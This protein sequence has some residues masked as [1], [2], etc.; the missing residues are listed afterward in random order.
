MVSYTPENMW[1]E[2]DDL[3]CAPGFKEVQCAYYGGIRVYPE[4]KIVTPKWV[5]SKRQP[6]F[7][8]NPLSGE[9]LTP[10]TE[11]NLTQFEREYSNGVR[12]IYPWMLEPLQT[13]TTIK[14]TNKHIIGI[15]AEEK[16]KKEF[17]NNPDYIN[18]M[19]LTEATINNAIMPKSKKKA[20]KTW[21]AQN[22]FYSSNLLNYGGIIK[23]DPFIKGEQ[24]LRACDKLN[25]EVK[26]EKDEKILESKIIKFVE[27]F[28]VFDESKTDDSHYTGLDNGQSLYSFIETVRII[29]NTIELIENLY[30]KHNGEYNETENV[31]A[32]MVIVD[33]I[34]GLISGINIELVYGVAKIDKTRYGIEIIKKYRTLKQAVGLFLLNTIQKR[35]GKEDIFSRCGSVKCNGLILPKN[36]RRKWCNSTCRSNARHNRKKEIKE[37]SSENL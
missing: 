28:G 20:I 26:S 25:I 27:K 33:N 14:S 3:V 32:Y 37:A 6:V 30:K 5:N 34:N 23:Y 17:L 10:L 2:N 18:A 19:N 36:N 7:F 4:Y 31:K 9:K 21:K 24:I 15:I 8:E 16:Y 29:K 35:K 11:S 13:Q 22:Q 12:E 1:E